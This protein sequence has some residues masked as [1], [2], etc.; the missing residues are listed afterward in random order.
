MKQLP[1]WRSDRF[2][3]RAISL[4]VIFSMTALGVSCTATSSSNLSQSVVTPINYVA[5]TQALG[6]VVIPARSSQQQE[7]RLQS[8]AAYLQQILKLPVNIQIA[9]N[10]ETAVDLLAKEKVEM[11]Y[12]GALTYLKARDR[13]PNIEPLVLPIEQTTG[14]PWY[15]GVII[16]NSKRGINS[17][18]DLKGK[19]FAF[20]SPSSTS[21][22]LMPMNAFIQQGIDPTRDF[23]RIRYSGS[24]DKAETDLETDVVDAIATEKAIF[25][26]SQREGKLKSSQYKIIWESEPIPTTPIV[27]NTKKFSPSVINQLKRALID[28]PEGLVDVNGSNSHGYT[29]GKDADFEQIRQIYTRLKSVVVAAK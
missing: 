10:Y 17:L 28:A 27:I 8:L 26:Q 11:A 25:V 21:G 20:V 12:L 29:L 13:N 22:F 3:K 18:Q 16:A 4:L 19:R 14:R 23:T 24:H 15:S 5:V 9:K 7:K 2:F 1:F 6:V